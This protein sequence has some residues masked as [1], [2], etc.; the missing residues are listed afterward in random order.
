MMRPLSVSHVP[1]LRKHIMLC[2]LLPL[3][4]LVDPIVAAGIPQ[5]IWGDVPSIGPM[6]GSMDSPIGPKKANG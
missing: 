3:K 1:T 2:S 5:A 4:I 6:K